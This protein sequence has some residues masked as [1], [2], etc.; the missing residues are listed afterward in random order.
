[1][2][3]RVEQV[4][5]TAERVVAGDLSDRVP[6]RRHRR[7]IRP[8]RRQ[9]ERNA[10]PDRAADDR[11]ARGHRQCRARSEDAAR[12]AAGAAGAGAARAAGRRCPERGDTGRDR[13][14]RPAAGDLQRAA[15]HRRGGSRRRRAR[16]AAR[17][18]RDRRRRGRA[19]RAACRGEGRWRCGSTA[20]PARSSTATATCCRKPSPT[21]STMRSN[22]AG[23]AAR[24]RSTVRPARRLRGDRGRRS[25]TG[26]PRG[27]SRQRVRS[28]RAVG[29]EPQHARQRA[30]PQPGA[31]G[32]AAAWRHR[33][34]GRQFSRAQAP[35][36]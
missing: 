15:R 24:S 34:V 21:C 6:R 28:I 1:M 13:G 7:R 30:W 31:R 4:N 10:R 36:A 11:D 35:R 19:I 26:N 20:R 33:H 27:G 17:S 14:G 25:G 5:R 23:T 16:R 22:T 9:P 29:A 8:A 18:R 2:L 3:R 32:G 12:A